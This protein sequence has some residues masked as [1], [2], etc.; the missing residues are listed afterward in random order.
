MGDI[1]R[2]R[3][4]E[5]VAAVLGAYGGRLNFQQL[6]LASP[7]EPGGVVH[8][9]VSPTMEK[10]SLMWVT[11]AKFDKIIH[12]DKQALLTWYDST[13]EE[14]GGTGTAAA[15]A[16]AGASSRAPTPKFELVKVQ[17]PKPA[18]KPTAAPLPANR[19]Q[20]VTIDLG[21]LVSRY[22][23]RQY[24]TEPPPPDDVPAA[25][26]SGF[27][28]SPTSQAAGAGAGKSSQMLA[29]LTLREMALWVFPGPTPGASL[30]RHLVSKLVASEGGGTRGLPPYAVPYNELAP[31]VADSFVS[32]WCAV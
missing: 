14:R 23:N 10:E 17:H 5:V 8:K 19:F 9:Y 24:D 6:L 29:A 20:R 12:L 21:G 22:G 15:A 32:G 30:R 4:P 3:Y 16:R 31:E 28:L 18:A 27:K 11:Q 7:G 1:M 26:S 13:A 2:R 25:A